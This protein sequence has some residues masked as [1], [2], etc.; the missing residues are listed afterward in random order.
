MVSSS[1]ESRER[2]V[3]TF[4]VSFQKD[5][6]SKSEKLIRRLNLSGLSQKHDG[7]WQL[8]RCY[9]RIIAVLQKL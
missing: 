7:I 3:Y 4:R 5:L 6:R 1:I 2:N 9:Y 8:G